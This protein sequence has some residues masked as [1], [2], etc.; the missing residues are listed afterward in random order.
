MTPTH[1]VEVADMGR[2]AADELALVWPLRALASSSISHPR[3]MAT[4]SD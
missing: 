1:I 3:A 4:P 2:K